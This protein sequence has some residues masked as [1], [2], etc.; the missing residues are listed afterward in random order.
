MYFNLELKS[1]TDACGARTKFLGFMIHVGS[2]NIKFETSYDFWLPL[3]LTLSPKQNAI[4][5][6]VLFALK[7]NFRVYNSPLQGFILNQ[8]NSVHGLT[9]YVFKIHVTIIVPFAH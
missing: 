2:S 4:K 9:S 1:F 3:D 8:M 5:I 7:V 6:S